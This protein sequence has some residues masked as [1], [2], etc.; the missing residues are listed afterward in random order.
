MVPSIEQWSQRIYS[1]QCISVTS[2][3][4]CFPFFHSLPS[5]VWA[6]NKNSKRHS[7]TNNKVN[8]KN[9]PVLTLWSPEG[10]ARFRY[11]HPGFFGDLNIRNRLPITYFGSILCM[12][13]L[14]LQCAGPCQH[15][16]AALGYRIVEVRPSHKLLLLIR[17]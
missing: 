6:K 17:H 7:L 5:Y 13:Y 11:L 15:M 4:N 9:F 1:T 10:T 16:D 2:E 3:S 14:Y 8:V 12:L